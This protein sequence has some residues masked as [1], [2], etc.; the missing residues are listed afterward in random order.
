[1]AHTHTH[2]HKHTYTHTHSP[3]THLNTLQRGLTP[4]VTTSWMID[5]LAQANPPIS[6]SFE[7]SLI[8][9]EGHYR[10]SA[11]TTGPQPIRGEA[12]DP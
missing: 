10:G 2:M 7:A 6:I 12:H 3:N 11:G 9:Q 5:S 4:E 1:M 8:R